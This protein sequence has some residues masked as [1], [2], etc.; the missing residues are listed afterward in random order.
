MVSS[1]IVSVK[2]TDEAVYVSE[3]YS[4]HQDILIIYVVIQLAFS[5]QT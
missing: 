2:S 4:W 1:G 5:C 3:A